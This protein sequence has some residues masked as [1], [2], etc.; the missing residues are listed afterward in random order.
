[1]TKQLRCYFALAIVTMMLVIACNPETQLQT[2]Q[3]EKPRSPTRSNVL[4][5][6]WDK[7]F[8]LEED[9]ALEQI[10]S[11]WQKESGNKLKLSFYSNDELPE[12]AQRAIQAGT[13]PDLVMGSSAERELNPRLAWEGKLVDVSDIIAPVKDS[14]SKSALEAVNFYNNVE[15]KRSYYGIPI[16]QLTIHVFYWRDLLEQ[17]GKN[18]TNIP[19]DWNNF[20]QFWQDV[21]NDLAR[22]LK[23]SGQQSP[24]IYGLGFPL[25]AGG[26][27]TYYLFE[28]ILEARDISILDADGNL[29][30]DEPKV[31]QGIIDSFKW[32]TDFYIAG[33]I[34]PDA[35]NWLNPDNNRNL[36][37]RS[38]VM[39]PNTTLSI[40]AAVRKD[41]DTNLEK[42]GI[43]EFPNKLNKDPT[44]HLVAVNAVVLLSASQ[45]QELA[46]DFLRY[47]VE[48]NTLSNYLKV[49]GGRYLPVMDSVWKT[50]GWEDS[51]DEHFSTAAKTVIKGK[52][53]PF[54]IVTNPAYAIIL[55]K[56]IWGKALNRIVVNGIS[57]EQAADEAIAQIQDIF[58]NWD[59]N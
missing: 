27:D 26:A 43:I 8:T 10:V 51:D 11:N 40:P 3:V 28:Q 30:I 57:P 2:I 18:E 44:R 1:M 42:L 21:Q 45:H 20:W 39:T 32:Y 36:L 46:K 33:Y 38:I 4:E 7:G 49:S 58:A 34:P 29:I 6:W 9:E 15:K 16:S 23:L 59:K 56:N 53:R 52:T 17:V 25:S 19:R 14:Y 13:A 54:N 47:L 48:P 41:A 55:Q 22:Q 31:R 5:I 50:L 35:V 12:K 37:R 24:K